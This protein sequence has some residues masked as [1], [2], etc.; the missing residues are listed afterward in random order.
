M[1]VQTREKILTNLS[2]GYK[3]NA[4]SLSQKLSLIA[5]DTKVY[6]NTGGKVILAIE[7]IQLVSQALTLYPAQY[8]NPNGSKS[9]LLFQILMYLIQF[10]TPTS[11]VSLEGVNSTASAMLYIIVALTILKF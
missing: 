2:F 8:N 4:D 1:N 9:P 7:Y 5:M 6:S 11:I 10:V 3:R